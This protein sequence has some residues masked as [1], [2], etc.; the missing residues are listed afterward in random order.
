MRN[1]FTRAMIFSVFVIIISL[2]NF[3]TLDGRESVTSVQIVTLLV[4]GAA[5]GIFLQNL[6]GYLMQKREK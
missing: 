4:C 6:I 5:I 1:K 2:L 3:S